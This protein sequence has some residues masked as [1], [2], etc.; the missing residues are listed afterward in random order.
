MISP[1][2]P[3]PP[4]KTP[5]VTGLRRAVYLAAAGLFFLLGM[6]GVALP[7]LPTTPFLLVCSYFLLRA[8][9]SLHQR[10]LTA[11]VVG[12]LLR[13]WNEHRGLRP[14]VKFRAMLLVA[15]LLGI[16]ITW[17]QL[18]TWLTAMVIGLGGIGLAVI[19]YLPTI[20]HER[21]ESPKERN[22]VITRPKIVQRPVAEPQITDRAD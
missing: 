20:P 18:S 10:L 4:L 1:D 9:P 6:V 15:L 19:A 13:D 12:P 14:E 2:A 8:S 5:R 3:Y 21:P 22:L 11:R 16:S 7:G 17:G